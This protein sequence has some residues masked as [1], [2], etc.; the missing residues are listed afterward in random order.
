V[1]KQ[2]LFGE[3]GGSKTDWA[4][5]IENNVE[6]RFSSESLHP[7]KWNTEVFNDLLYDFIDRK[8]DFE[9]TK[10]IIFGAGCHSIEQAEKLKTYF[11]IFGFQDVEVSG[12]LKAAGIATLSES[13]GFV[14]ILGS[15]SVLVNFKNESVDNYFGGVG[16]EHGD[17]GA[18]FYFGKLVLDR[19]LKRELSPIQD[20]ILKSHLSFQEQK[21][22][23]R[24]GID[25][26]LC[27]QLSERLGENLFEFQDIHVENSELFFQKYVN[28]N[29]PVT[30][31]I[32]F[33]GSYAFFH[34]EIIKSHFREKGFDTGKFIARPIENI[35]DYYK[36]RS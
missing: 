25:E 28:G 10:L 6:W 31:T 2:I 17:E 19:Y 23:E 12:D 22:V 21:A 14:A 29:V 24:G 8:I 35:V 18:G 20:S 26:E 1:K 15:G 34:Q 16:R 13:N 7:K 33:V 32:H 9:N 3:S 5:L 30:E 4:L 27:L 36:S 11:K